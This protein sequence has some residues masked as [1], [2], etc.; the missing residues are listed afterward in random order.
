MALSDIEGLPLKIFI[1]YF[2]RLFS[3]SE[4]PFWFSSQLSP[5]IL[6]FLVFLVC[7]QTLS[8]LASG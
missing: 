8:G 7:R 4:D 2:P 3:L 1:F 6:V 5:R